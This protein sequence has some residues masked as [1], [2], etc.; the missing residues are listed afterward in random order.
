MLHAG[1]RSVAEAVDRPAACAPRVVSGTGGLSFWVLLDPVSW[2]RLMPL[3]AGAGTPT[4]GG[5]PSGQGCS[6]RLWQAGLS[7]ALHGPGPRSRATLAL[8]PPTSLRTERQTRRAWVMGGGVLL[9]S[10]QEQP[11]GVPASG[12]WG[13]QPAGRSAVPTWAGGHVWYQKV[14]PSILR[15]ALG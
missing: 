10:M 1:Q 11:F 9:R 15:A 4:E 12:L 5:D 3:Q 7:T 14:A 2:S 8:D 13:T 6:H